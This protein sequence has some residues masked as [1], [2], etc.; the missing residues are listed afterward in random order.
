M[1]D[2]ILYL[3]LTYV[4]AFLSELCV[5]MISNLLT[6]YN[7]QGPG[8]GGAGGSRPFGPGGMFM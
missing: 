1:S 6:G 2:L 8:F 4:C 5:F 7:L 3:S